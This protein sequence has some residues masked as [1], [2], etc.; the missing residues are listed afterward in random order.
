[1]F[2]LSCSLCKT[3]IGPL[4]EKNCEQTDAHLLK[5]S[6]I[7]DALATKTDLL[8]VKYLDIFGNLEKQIKVT[9]VYK[10][11]FKLMEWEN[12]KLTLF[13]EN[14]VEHLQIIL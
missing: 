6:F 12:E 3:G 10:E 2:D 8:N 4:S 7:K 13:L 9:R 5:C 14:H 1:M 11:I